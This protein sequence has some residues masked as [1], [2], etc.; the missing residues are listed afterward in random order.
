MLSAPVV[1]AVAETERGRELY[2]R[3]A[4]TDAFASLSRAA[5]RGAG[6]RAAGHVRLHA[7][8]RRRLLR[9]PRARPSRAPRRRRPA[10]APRTARSGSGVNL[11]LQ[12][13][14]RPARPAGSARAQRLVEREGRDCVER[15]YLLIPAMFQHEA[16]GDLRGRGRHRRRGRSPSASDSA[17]ATCSRSPRSRRARSWSMQGRG[18]G[19]PGA[20]R[21]GDGRG[22]RGRAVA[23][24]QRARLLRRDPRL[25]GRVRAAPRPRVD[26]AR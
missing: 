18:R 7:R 3:R 23:D 6:P 25:P 9:L 10:C 11:M 14:A 20:A 19:G 17:T 24:R 12:R 21:R 4:W 2:A 26:H 16:A 5:A 22:H 1:D 13:R 15:G 8:P